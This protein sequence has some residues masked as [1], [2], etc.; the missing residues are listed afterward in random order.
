[1]RKV[2]LYLLVLGTG[3]VV[4]AAPLEGRP[5]DEDKDKKPS[6]SV[7]A[8]PPVSFSPAR[9]RAVAELK[10]GPDDYQELYCATVEWDWGDLTR[11]EEAADCEPYQAGVSEITRRFVGEHTYRTSGRFRVQIR[12]KRNNKVVAGANTTIT[13][14]P[15]LRDY[16]Y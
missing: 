16:G 10:G 2:W 5:D 11:S 14:R 6:L 12:L 7:R 1:M 9:I 3:W 8:T 13:V 4:P 15:G